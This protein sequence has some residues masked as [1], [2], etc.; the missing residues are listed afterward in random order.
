[1]QRGLVELGGLVDVAPGRRADDAVH[2]EAALLLVG[3]DRRLG[4]RAEVAV[5]RARVVAQRL[6][7]LLELA[8]RVAARSWFECRLGHRYPLGDRA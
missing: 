3:L 5:D 8:D 6:Q 4:L 7:R 1:M 2:R